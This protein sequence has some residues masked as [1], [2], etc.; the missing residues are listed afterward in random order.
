MN[1]NER[2][3]GASLNRDADF[4]TINYIVYAASGITS[5]LIYLFS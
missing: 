5:T 3:K 4:Y 2:D 1:E